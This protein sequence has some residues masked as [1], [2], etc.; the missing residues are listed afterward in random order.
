M[1]KPKIRWVLGEFIS[2]DKLPLFQ[3]A[4]I[5]RGYEFFS[6]PKQSSFGELVTPD[7]KAEDGPIIC[8]G[9]LTLIR[10]IQRLRDWCPGT[11]ANF[12]NFECSSY[13][14][15]FQKYLIN[16]EYVLLPLG[17]VERNWAKLKNYFGADKLFI[18]PN[19]GAKVFTGQ[20]LEDTKY[21]SS[22]P[23]FA[24]PGTI[25]LIAP[26]QKILG[27]ARLFVTKTRILGG[28]VYYNEIGD[29]Y[30]KAL[31]PKE[32]S[33]IFDFAQEVIS[34]TNWIPDPIYCMDV[35]ATEEGLKIVELNS[36]SCCGWY[37]TPVESVI[38]EVSKIALAEWK[39]IYA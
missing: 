13:Y 27:E 37:E 20:V 5:A 19:V 25:C 38:E 34:S 23:D 15:H 32:D 1:V 31:C 21:L 28:S 29:L 11:Y 36:L 35:A 22:L 14:P 33:D 26:A 16:R 4:V 2:E 12:S 6:I 7:L 10:R 24:P 18:R 30:A 8:L 3:E 39:D 9:D 17:D